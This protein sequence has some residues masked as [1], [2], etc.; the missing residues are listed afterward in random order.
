MFKFFIFP[1][2]LYIALIGLIFG[3]RLTSSSMLVAMGPT[4][5]EK[6][7][8]LR[9]SKAQYSGGEIFVPLRRH[10]HKLAGLQLQL[11]SKE[12]P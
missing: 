6:L 1:A 5:T 11:S 2:E 4:D 3:V 12:E 9:A 8:D 10:F 7:L